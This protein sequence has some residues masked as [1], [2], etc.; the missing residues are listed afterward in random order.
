MGSAPRARDGSCGPHFSLGCAQRKVA[1]AAVEKKGA[2]CPNPAFGGFGHVRG[3]PTRNTGSWGKRQ[4]WARSSSSQS[5]YPSLPACAESSLIPMLV[6]SP[7]KPLRWV[8]AGAPIL[9]NL[10]VVGPRPGI[11]RPG[12]KTDLVCFSFTVSRCGA[13]S[14]S[15]TSVPLVPPSAAAPS[16]AQVARSEAERAGPAVKA[17]R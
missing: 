17:F 3:G 9:L 12:C 13:P 1:A 11:A 4:R 10:S 2:L 8:F 14:I 5:P 15:V 6:L 7:R 16:T